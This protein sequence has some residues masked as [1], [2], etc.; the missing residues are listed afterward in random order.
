MHTILD[1]AVCAAREAGRVLMQYYAQR[2]R[3]RVEAKRRNDFVSEADRAAEAAIIAVIRDSYPGHGILAEES[4]SNGGS[5]REYQWVIDPL[6]GTTNFL[7]G[8][9]QFCVSIGI[10]RRGRLELGVI[11]DPLREELFTATRGGGAH[12][13]GWPIHVTD[14]GSLDGALIGTGFPIRDQRDI[15]AYVE[16]FREMTLATAGLRRAGSAALDLVN[17]AAGRTDGQFDLGLAQWDLAAGA[18]IVAEAGGVIT[19]LAGGNRYLERG[20]LIA[21]NPDIHRALRERL[22]PFLTERLGGP[23]GL[24]TERRSPAAGYGERAAAGLGQLHPG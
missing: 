8:F 19:D 16:M 1:S 24:T 18:I 6:D 7:H 10:K 22:G 14:R 17:V 2:D 4:G 23:R 12:L 5:Q 11:Y 21:G 13:N 20:N 15:G 9:P 3:L